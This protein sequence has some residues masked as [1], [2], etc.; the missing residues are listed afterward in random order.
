M[1]AH[2]PAAAR[3]VGPARRDE[4][5]NFGW[6]TYNAA[7][8]RPG[9]GS[10]VKRASALG[11]STLGTPFGGDPMGLPAGS[12]PLR[13]IAAALSAALSSTS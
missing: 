8:V 13:A 5:D 3:L 2:L 6:A 4:P 12:M 11:Q 9:G 1:G 7:R 10:F